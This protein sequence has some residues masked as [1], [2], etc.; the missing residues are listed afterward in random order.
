MRH[1]PTKF[2]LIALLLSLAL[3]A[4]GQE[5]KE[6]P[7]WQL[8]MDISKLILLQQPTL[9]FEWPLNPHHGLEL[10][11]GTNSGLNG[12]S[13]AYEYASQSFLG[14]LRHQVYLGE[15]KMGQAQFS[16]KHGP[17]WAV[18]KLH[19]RVT[20]WIQ[21]VEDGLTFYR[22]G[23]ELRTTPRSLLA[24][25]LFIGGNWHLGKVNLEIMGGLS[26]QAQIKTTPEL[27]VQRGRYGY[28]TDFWLYEGL[29]PLVALTLAYRH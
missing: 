6:P 27:P 4:T 8:G 16:L 2:R 12:S 15:V 28:Q 20:G 13:R 1:I 10:Q 5:K 21:E 7:H 11:V 22:Y 9:L 25:D 26:Y 17:S 23:S 14:A 3:S 19:Y 29:R 18:G 24:Y